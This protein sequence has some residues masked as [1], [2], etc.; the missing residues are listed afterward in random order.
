MTQLALDLQPPRA[1]GSRL[2]DLCADKAERVAGFDGQAAGKCI[3]ELL[4]ARGAMSG[5]EL[6]DAAMAQGHRP[7]DQRAFGPVYAR[8]AREG[9]I[10]CVGYCARRKGNG[11]AGGRLWGVA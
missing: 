2:G 6:T 8:L 9:L 10:R 5:E 4:R 1:S 3:V 7:H 11:T